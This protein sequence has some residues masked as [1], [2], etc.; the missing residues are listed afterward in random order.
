MALKPNDGLYFTNLGVLYHRW[1]RREEAVR[2]YSSA[3]RINPSNAAVA[4][5]LTQL[6]V[7]VEQRTKK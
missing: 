5:Y 6:G 7:S 2:A 1:G 4:D 3:L